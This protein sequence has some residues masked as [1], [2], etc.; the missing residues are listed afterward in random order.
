MHKWDDGE[1]LSLER[2]NVGRRLRFHDLRDIASVEFEKDIRTGGAFRLSGASSGGIASISDEGVNYSI[3]N[4][5]GFENSEAV[6][7]RFC[8][9]SKCKT[10]RP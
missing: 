1:L 9:V 4:S 8:W 6:Q 3:C 7:N 10:C 2:F 5:K